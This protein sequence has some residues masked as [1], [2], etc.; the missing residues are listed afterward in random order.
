MRFP[1]RTG[2][3]CRTAAALGLALLGLTAL[4]TP[5]RVAADAPASS[6]V[7]PTV[8]AASPAFRALT[9]H[10][11]AAVARA[12]AV[13]ALDS[14]R[15]LSLALTLPL[16]RPAELADL[17]RG[18]SDPSDARYGQFLTPQEFAD[19]FSPTQADYARV[20]AYARAMGLTVIATHPNRTVL[21][22]A[23]TA[24]QAERAFG[25][26]LLVYQGREDGRFF[27]A[28]DAEPRVPTALAG[29]VSGVIGLDNAARWRPH[30]RVRLDPM[31]SPFLDPYAVSHQTGSGPGGG[32]T[33]SDIKTAYNLAGVTQTGAGQTLALF[34]LDGY[35]ASDITAYET[36]F[37]LPAIPLQNVLVDGYSGASGSGAGEVTLDI[38]L[39]AALAPGA[40]KIVVYEAPNSS[41]GV[42]DTYN[43]IA[44][45]NAAKEIST[46]WGE[47]ENSASASVRSSENAAFQQ[48]SAQG[49]SIFAAAGD[50]GAYDDG[51]ALSVDDP[52]SQPYMTGV[53]GT[54]LTTAGPGGAYSSEKTWATPSDTRS[55]PFG[56]GGGGGISTVWSL[57]AYQSGVA[58]SAAS[59][60][61]TTMRNVPDVSLDA[62]SNTG[63]A[64]YFNG[65]WNIYGGTSCAAPLWS[66]FT[67]LVNQQRAANGL[68]TLGF[69]NTPLY[70]IGKGANYTAD[71]HDIADGSTNLFYPA[72]AGYDDATGL[73]TFNGANLLA[74]LSGGGS[75]PPAVPAAPTNL[76]ATAGNAQVALAWTGSAGATSYSV[77]RGTASGGETLLKSGLT[78]TSYTDTG[79]TNGTTYFYQVA[80]VNAGGTSAKS[81]EAGAK[82]TAPVTAAQLLGNPGF[83]NGAANPAPWVASA[84]VIDNSTGEAAH[85]GAWKA[86]LNGYGTTHT[87]TLS[88]TVAIPSAITKATL[89][90][91]L[92]IDTAETTKTSAYD[93]LKVQLRSSSGA[94]LKTL[95]TYSNLNAATGY[96]LKTFDVSAYKG[97]TI[98]V[99]LVGAEDS[100]LQTSFVAD[101]FALNVQ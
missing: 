72:V 56:A 100:S 73:G 43:K 48:M 88:Q 54:A 79:L 81:G 101:D 83:E 90:F 45:D 74:D 66:A 94:V 18:L 60:G 78:A 6:T 22:V 71:F 17:L 4:G 84:G 42:V 40:S 26:H 46:S 92:H 80:A 91:Y 21:D 68:G 97:Q 16:R 38:E 14:S 53:G 61:S 85:S 95:A 34:E 24:G 96:S 41:A 58:G 65:A 89:N 36:K 1:S 13:G 63:Y 47:A 20:A 67:A 93:T 7:S 87:D 31:L 28:P 99:Y 69:A 10:I 75:A 9:G 33:P 39:Q 51:S 52:A 37:G 19:R 35:K 11:P 77:Y 50:S 8:S 70:A 57:P 12:Q 5:D 30:S 76:T 25:L 3:A 62:D 55:S 44:T 82:P 59:K 64:I 32:L 29:L 23:A 49:Q 98:Q 86:W 15:T 2:R 27:Y